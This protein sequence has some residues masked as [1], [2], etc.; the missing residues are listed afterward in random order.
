MSDHSI[1]YNLQHPGNG[2]LECRAA[3]SAARTARRDE[4]KR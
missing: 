2:E 4:E 3:L 1:V